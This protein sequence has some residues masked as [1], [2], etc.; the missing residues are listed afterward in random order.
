MQYRDAGGQ[1]AIVTRLAMR[2]WAGRE[3]CSKGRLAVDNERRQGL[4]KESRE[5]YSVADLSES[6]D[7]QPSVIVEWERD[8]CNSALGI[9]DLSGLRRWWRT[10]R[11]WGEK[12]P[13]SG[14]SSVEAA[15]RN[16]GSKPSKRH[17]LPLLTRYVDVELN[18]EQSLVVENG[19]Y[20]Q[21]S[22]KGII[23]H[24]AIRPSNKRRRRQCSAGKA[25]HARSVTVVSATKLT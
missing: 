18:Y 25:R 4:E 9:L 23:H 24:Q 3:Q 2:C 20:K 11:S 19:G 1:D 10:S 17:S 14:E 22:G 7:V 16:E 21:S 5:L 15:R 13:R 6:T 8:T 12:V